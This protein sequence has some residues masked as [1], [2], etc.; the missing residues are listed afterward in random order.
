MQK[1]VTVGEKQ[2]NPFIWTSPSNKFFDPHCKKINR[3][4]WEWEIKHNKL[5]VL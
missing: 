4:Y 5:K 1:L 2:S 3:K